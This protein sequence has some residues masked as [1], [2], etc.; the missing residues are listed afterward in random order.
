MLLLREKTER[1][2]GLQA[3][4]VI[5]VG[6]DRDKILAASAVLLDDPTAY[7]RLAQIRNPYGDGCASDRIAARISEFLGG[8]TF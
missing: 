3:G 2:E 5:V 8:R 7:G 6:T 4:A 1:P